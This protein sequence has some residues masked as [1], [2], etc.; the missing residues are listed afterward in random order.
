MKRKERY[1]E[2]KNPKPSSKI[3]SPEAIYR[4]PVNTTIYR[5]G[6]KRVVV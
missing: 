5:E 4:T 2:R 3:Q 6:L 1:I